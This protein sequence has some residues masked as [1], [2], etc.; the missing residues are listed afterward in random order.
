[1][2]RVGVPATVLAGSIAEPAAAEKNGP[3]NATDPSFDL[4]PSTAIC[5]GQRG[6][7][8][9]ISCRSPKEVV[10]SLAWKSTLYVWGGPV[11]GIACLYLLL[12]YWKS[13]SS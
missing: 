7:P 3:G 1:M 9:T 5:K 4:H 10:E 13:I 12:H 11:L 8:Y 2:S 6:D